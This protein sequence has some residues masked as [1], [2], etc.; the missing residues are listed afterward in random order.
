VILNIVG[1]TT[2]TQNSV[3]FRSRC[4]HRLVLNVLNTFQVSKNLE[5]VWRKQ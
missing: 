2:H 4:L 5:G 1:I 3:S